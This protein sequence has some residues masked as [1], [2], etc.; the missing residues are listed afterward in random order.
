[1]NFMC[2][3]AS[4][5]TA[6]RRFS[7]AI[8]L[9]LG[10]GPCDPNRYMADVWWMAFSISGYVNVLSSASHCVGSVSPAPGSDTVTILSKSPSDS[11]CSNPTW[12]IGSGSYPLRGLPSMVGVS[13]PL[14]WW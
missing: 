2:L 4:R 10:D 7:R 12:V 6:Q 9:A 13:I 5:A 11:R 3:S 1:M 8:P 14:S